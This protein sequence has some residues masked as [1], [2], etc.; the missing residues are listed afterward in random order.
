MRFSQLKINEEKETTNGRKKRNLWSFH[1]GSEPP[2]PQRR[3][4]HFLPIPLAWSASRETCFSLW[5]PQWNPVR[6]SNWHQTWRF[7]AE[8]C[9]IRHL[10]NWH[11]GGGK[12]VFAR[13]APNILCKRFPRRHFSSVSNGGHLQTVSSLHDHQPTLISCSGNKAAFL[14]NSVV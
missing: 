1:S 5:L 3:H 2:Y 10:V 8:L 9:E 11:Q 6:F 14:E 4:P 12:R 7:F 13:T